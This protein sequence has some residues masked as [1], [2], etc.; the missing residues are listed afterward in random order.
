MKLA[1]LP[2]SRI[3]LLDRALEKV[4]P[5]LL[6]ATVDRLI[7]TTEARYGDIPQ[8]AVI[9]KVAEQVRAEALKALGEPGCANCE[10]ARGWI[11]VTHA[12]GVRMERCGC[13]RRLQSKREALQVGRESL[14]LPAGDDATQ[15]DSMPLKE[16]IA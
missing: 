11:A 6:M 12:D 8:T 16:W 10:D 2:E 1:N 9:L 13:F 15:T 3:R 5:T 4:P 14:A 7:Q